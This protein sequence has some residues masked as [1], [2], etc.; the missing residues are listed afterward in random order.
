MLGEPLIIEL[1]P[2]LLAIRL[3]RGAVLLSHIPS[4]SLEN[5]RQMSTTVSHTRHLLFKMTLLTC[6]LG[7]H[8]LHGV[9]VEVKSLHHVDPGDRIWSSGLEANISISELSPQPLTF[10]FETKTY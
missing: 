7:W 5:F 1:G 4:P 10:Y 2:Q 6:L 8:K 3:Y 9:H